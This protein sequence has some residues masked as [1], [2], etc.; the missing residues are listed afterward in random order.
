MSEKVLYVDDDPNILAAHRRTLRNQFTVETAQGGREGLEI[1]AHNGPFAVVISDMRMPEMDGVEFL[2]KVKE[3]TPDI[4][5]IMLT[6]NADLQTSIDAVNKGKIFQFLT[7]PC[8]K[9]TLVKSVEMALRQYQ[10]IV[11]ERQLLEETLNGSIQVMADIL[12]MVSP[13]AFGRSGRIRRYVR[14][15]AEK[16]SLSNVWEIEIAAMLSQVG[17]VSLPRET[18]EKV[19]ADQDLTSKEREMFTSHP[20]VGGRLIVNIPRL[21]NAAHMIAHQNE[22]FSWDNTGE[23]PRNRNIVAVGG[24][25]L[26]V[27]L[28]FDLLVI[29][30]LS[31]ETALAKLRGRKDIY[32][33]DIVDAIADIQITP[34]ENQRQAVRVSELVPGMILD[35]KVCS[36]KGGLLIPK[37]QEVTI[38]ILEHLRRWSQGIGVEEPIRV[39]VPNYS[40]ETEAVA[41]G[42]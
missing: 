36:T 8:P 33:P 14:H 11:A 5:R 18:L 26:K 15:I 3:I 24:H 34:T 7:K 35:E 29:R 23:S 28:D 37:G 30:G 20:D 9:E 13:T 22:P 19:Y 2:A 1:I 17:C 4:V 27:A 10:L 32:D 41:V 12:S 25:I 31:P 16:L 39:L 21:G 38:P 42:K 6:G 40:N